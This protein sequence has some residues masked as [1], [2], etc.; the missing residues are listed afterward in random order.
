MRRDDPL[1]RELATLDEDRR[2]LV[3]QRA[4]LANELRAVLKEYF[5]AVLAMRPAQM[6]ADFVLRFLLKFPTLQDAQ[7][8]SV[9]SLRAC[10]NGGTGEQVERRVDV[11]RNATPLTSDDVII[12]THSRRATGL[13]RR[14]MVLS[15]L[16]DGY[17][18]DLALLVEQHDN[19]A[20]VASLPA[21]S[22]VTHCRIIAAMVFVVG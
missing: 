11:I 17:D 7:S 21:S 6:H 14:I 3:D 8:A 9:R 13:C 5:P 16:I 10:L 4:A 2:Q 15:D 19:H 20:I 22:H 18:E 1:T 12:S